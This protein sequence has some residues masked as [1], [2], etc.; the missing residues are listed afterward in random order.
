VGSEL[1]KLAG[2]ISLFRSA[3]GVHWRSDYTESVLLGERVAIAMLQEMSLGFNE[4]DGFFE[5][6]RL[7]GTRI[8]IRDGVVQA[9]V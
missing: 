5:L 4:D 6:G 9:T 2:N 1:N 7:D 8:R 3:A